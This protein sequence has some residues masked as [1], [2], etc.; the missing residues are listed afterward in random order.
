M[1]LCASNE[2]HTQVK[3]VEV[4][5][6]AKPGDRVVFPG[7][8]GREPAAPNQMAKKKIFEKLAPQLRT[9]EVGV[10]Q[11]ADLPFLVGKTS[12]IVVAF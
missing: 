5:A 4:P 1:V 10:A 3:F 8:E 11:W 12:S 6:S 2:D 9:N 7:F